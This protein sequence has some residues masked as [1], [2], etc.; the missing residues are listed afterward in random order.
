MAAP[1]SLARSASPSVSYGPF[2]QIEAVPWLLLAATMRM[3]AYG[4]GWIAWPAIV[5]ANVALLLAFVIVAWRRV[6][7]SEGRS[8]L[9]RM[10]FSRQLGMTRHVLMPIFGLL[11]ATTIAAQASGLFAQPQ[12]F[13]L[14]F[15]GVAFDQRTHVGRLWSAFIAAVV[16]L[17]VLQVE[18]SEKPSLMRALREFGRRIGWLLPGVLLLAAISILIAPVQAWF[19]SWIRDVW[20]GQGAP[21]GLKA[22]LSL[23][24]VVIF[25]TIRLW[26]TVA[27][28]VFA[29]RQSYR[30]G[31]TADAGR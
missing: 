16:L 7:A 23:S 24:Y 3:L 19:R 12:E 9:G 27:V 6:L 14:G 1:R 28:L 31:Q 11:I 22:L 21:N 25:A 2:R 8:E 18:E 13:M 15:D 29:L 20:L 30:A 10:E 17:M 4:G 26:L 5:V